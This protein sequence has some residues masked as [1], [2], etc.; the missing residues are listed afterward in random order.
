M[1]AYLPKTNPKM[2]GISQ[3]T[4]ADVEGSMQIKATEGDDVKKITL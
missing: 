4:V 1:F 3:N 2:C